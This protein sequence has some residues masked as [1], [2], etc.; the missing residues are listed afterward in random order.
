MPYF[1]KNFTADF[2]TSYE[3]EYDHKQ[4]PKGL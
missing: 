4:T 1:D 3:D 2:F